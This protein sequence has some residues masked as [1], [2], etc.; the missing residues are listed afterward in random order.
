MKT[1]FDQIMENLKELCE[2][3]PSIIKTV[4]PS[5]VAKRVIERV[6][7]EKMKKSQVAFLSSEA[8]ESLKGIHPDYD[9]LATRAA[10]AELHRNT[11]DSIQE[12]FSKIMKQTDARS[13]E[14]TALLSKG[15]YLNILA[16]SAVLQRIVRYDRDHAICYSTLKRMLALNCLIK[17]RKKDKPME[18]PQ[19][20]LIRLAVALHGC[21]TDMVIQ[22]YEMMSLQTYTHAWQALANAGKPFEAHLFSCCVLA[23]K[24]ESI[25]D[26]FEAVKDCALFLQLSG[27]SSVAMHS[28][29][30]SD[31][32]VNEPLKKTNGIDALLGVYNSTAL[33][34]EKPFCNNKESI[35]VYL[36]IWHAQ[37]FD[38]VEM[39]LKNDEKEGLKGRSLLHHHHHHHHHHQTN[40]QQLKKIRHG[41]WMCDL[42][43]KRV[44]DDST[45]SLFCPNETP[46]LNDCYGETFEELYESYE[47]RGFSKHV[48]LARRLWVAILD[49]QIKTGLPYVV[50]KDS[51]NRCSNQ[52][53]L[54]TIQSA[55]FDAGLI[56]YASPNGTTLGNVACVSLACFVVD[57]SSC[58]QG[59]SASCADDPK[60]DR[61]QRLRFDHKLL[62]QTVHAMVKDLNRLIDVTFYPNEK[63]KSANMFHRPIGISVQGLADVFLMMRLQWESQEARTLNREIF[64]TIHYSA[65]EASC[66]LSQKDGVHEGF[67]DS[68]ASKGFLHIDL[69]RMNRRHHVDHSIPP[70]CQG[71]QKNNNNN[72]SGLQTNDDDDKTEDLQTS[73]RWDW[74]ALRTSIVAHGLRNSLLT[75]ALSTEP[76]FLMLHGNTESFEPAS[77]Y[78]SKNSNHVDPCFYSFNPH[79]V[80]HLTQRGLWSQEVKDWI[81]ATNGSVQD[82]PGIPDDLKSVYKTVWEIPQRLLV[83]MAIARSPFIDQSQSMN[84]YFVNP[85]FVRLNSL[86]FYAW[87]NGLKTGMRCL[88][89]RSDSVDA[90]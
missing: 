32:F 40:Q 62:R 56:Q 18:R 31:P 37:V 15:T 4:D 73:D 3:E 41:I 12:T 28:T 58:D 90:V 89:I 55:D 33:Y 30:A 36:E 24:E 68:P 67:H 7:K 48:L 29:I 42:F 83:D 60:A 79:L 27:R 51:S 50:Y 66:E 80:R 70:H 26:A 6:T 5:L 64:E 85:D 25:S 59:S 84:A 75:A 86:H 63:C 11:K 8:A 34:V 45:W 81:I 74:D 39:H 47:K 52:K 10:I 78:V 53:H 14:K 46:G 35:A 1:S 44:M 20:M 88:Y 22:C 71:F 38:F 21:K 23:P 19:H 61:D 43:M 69:W 9:K 82:V 76:T 2:M 13:K 77:C 87:R 72:A 54:G 17:K 57:A 16:Q 65:L 49:S